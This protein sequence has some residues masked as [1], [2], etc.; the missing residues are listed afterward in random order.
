MYI[1]K[2]LGLELESEN[3]SF[4]CLNQI[5]A[6]KTPHTN[7]YHQ[8]CHS[9]PFQ[10]AVYFYVQSCETAAIWDIIFLSEFCRTLLSF[11]ALIL[12]HTKL[13]FSGRKKKKKKQQLH[14]GI[15]LLPLLE[16]QLISA[17]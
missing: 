4:D 16:L 13:S 8:V 17:A 9:S 3:S 12:I 6:S 2:I 11:A 7:S 5:S 15:C 14:C 1:N 10:G